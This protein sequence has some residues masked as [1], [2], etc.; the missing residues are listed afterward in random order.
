MIGGVFLSPTIDVDKQEVKQGDTIAIF[1]E[2]VPGQQINIQVNSAQTLF[3]QTTSTA[4]GAYLYDLD[5]A[6]LAMGSHSTKSKAVAGSAISEDSVLKS[7]IVGNQD[8]AAQSAS[9]CPAKGDLNGDCKVNLVDFSMLAYWYGK[10]N[11][12]K[13]YLLDGKAKV[14]LA[15]FSIMAYY[16]TG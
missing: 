16:W 15:D 12:P 14:D 13:T 1:G 11:A 2:S 10:P 5:T 7:F 9:T 6:V 3:L 8:I 4:N